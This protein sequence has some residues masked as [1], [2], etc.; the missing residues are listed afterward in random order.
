MIQLELPLKTTNHNVITEKDEIL[1]Y[2]L[3][4]LRQ[5]IMLEALGMK[6]RGKSCL[7]IAKKTLGYSAR[8][9]RDEILRALDALINTFST[10]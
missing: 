7:S 6:K 2:Q 1:R 3:M 8:T 4:V 5:G 9:N 10:K